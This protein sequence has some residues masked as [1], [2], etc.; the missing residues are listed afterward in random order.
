MLK[1]KLEEQELYLTNTTTTVKIP[2]KEFNKII[3]NEDVVVKYWSHSIKAPSEV[4]TTLREKIDWQTRTVKIFG[5]EYTPTR[6]TASYGDRDLKYKYSG[7]TEIASTWIPELLAVKNQVEEITGHN[8][9]FVLCNLYKS[10][11]DYIGPH[12]DSEIDLDLSA[13]I[14]S[15]SLGQERDFILHHKTDRTKNKTIKLASGSLLFMGGSCQSIYKHSLPKRKLVTG[16]RINLT[17][18]VIKPSKK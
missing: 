9:N 16:E 8:Y 17:F 15:V 12:S 6:L 14:A 18:R 10:G 5:N 1:R 4:M 7:V 2:R 3:D 13:G 11:N